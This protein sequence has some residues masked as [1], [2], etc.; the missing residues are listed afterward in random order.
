M[1]RLAKTTRAGCSAVTAVPAAIATAVATGSP[2]R[3]R[4]SV[5]CAPAG[6][7][8]M[9][10]SATPA[11]AT[12]AASFQL[13]P[14]GR[15]SPH[16]AHMRQ[17]WN[18]SPPAPAAARAGPPA[19]AVAAGSG[20]AAAAPVVAVV[21]GP[22]RAFAAGGRVAVQ[23]IDG[24]AIG[25]AI[26]GGAVRRGGLPRR[27]PL[28]RRLLIGVRPSTVVVLLPRAILVAIDVAILARVDV[29]AVSD[30]YAA[31]VGPL[32]ASP[33]CPHPS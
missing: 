26:G 16:D 18:A 22:L 24:A 2:T 19:T 31:A 9:N 23:L 11:I 15:I 25:G 7:D 14:D 27:R 4:A 6:C 12:R 29:A 1:T 10:R 17:A 8:G 13:I 5:A 21:P 28:A 30:R 20:H 3:R 33:H 32:A